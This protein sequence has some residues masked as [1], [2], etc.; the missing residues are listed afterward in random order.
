[1]PRPPTAAQA[2]PSAAVHSLAGDPT[3]DFHNSSGGAYVA[4]PTLGPLSPHPRVCNVRA[5]HHDMSMRTCI[6]TGSTYREGLCGHAGVRANP[7]SLACASQYMRAQDALLL[8]A[9]ACAS[10]LVQG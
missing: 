9:G 8:A 2:M 5:L 4:G 6:T 10:S 7:E 1:M 3:N